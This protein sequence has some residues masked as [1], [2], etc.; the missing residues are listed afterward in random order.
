M[1][2]RYYDIFEDCGVK[3]IQTETGLFKWQIE[4]PE[5]YRT[6]YDAMKAAMEAFGYTK[7]NEK[8]SQATNVIPMS[9]KAK[10]TVDV[11]WE[12]IVPLGNRYKD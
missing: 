3:I 1:D 6:P 12:P 9:A 11:E 5:K 8:K 10:V 2:I 4:S 7:E